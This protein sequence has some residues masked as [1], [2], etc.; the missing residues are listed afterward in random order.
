MKSTLTIQFKES[1]YPNTPNHCFM[2]YI[3]SKKALFIPHGNN[4]NEGQIKDIKQ[5]SV[6]L[7][8]EY[9]NI[10]TNLNNI[11]N[12]YRMLIMFQVLC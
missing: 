11:G 10:N 3:Y 1:T 9:N 4:P 6:G 8:C 12:P 7:F 5:I 2:I